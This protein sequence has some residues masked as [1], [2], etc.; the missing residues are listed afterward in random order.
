MVTK[1]QIGRLYSRIDELAAQWTWRTSLAIEFG[2]ATPSQRRI[3]V[4]GIKLLITLVA[5]AFVPRPGRASG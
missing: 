3:R 2:C 5:R 4:A 1:H